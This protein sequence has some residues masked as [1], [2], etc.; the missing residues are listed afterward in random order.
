M[1]DEDVVAR[2]RSLSWVG[3]LLA[4]FDLELDRASLPE[5][6]VR[7]A[8]G[9]ALEPVAGDAAGGVFL[10]VG[11]PADR[12]PV[13]YAGSEGEGGLIASSLHAVVALSVGLPSLHDAL[14]YGWDPDGGARLRAWLAEC[15][16][17]IRDDWPELDQ[18]R[19]RVR[20]AL[21]LADA[22]D[23]LAGLHRAMAD[24][25]YRPI[26]PDNEPYE[27]MLPSTAR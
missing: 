2:I 13:V 7:L 12:R 24:D 26:G 27:S 18:A 9:R 3:D 22:Y 17:Y 1:R 21:A 25:T 5:E 23:L 6:G 8:D 15:D 16:G 14:T 10:L 20:E 19:A 11:P 4:R